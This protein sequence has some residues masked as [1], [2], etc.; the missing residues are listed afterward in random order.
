MQP[1]EFYEQDEWFRNL[2]GA[3]KVTLDKLI[4]LQKT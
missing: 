1:R 3:E 2:N 4:T